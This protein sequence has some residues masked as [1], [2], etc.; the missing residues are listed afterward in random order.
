MVEICTASDGAYGVPRMHQ[1]LRQAGNQINRKRVRR[2]MRRHGMAISARGG[3]DNVTGVITH[4]DRGSQYTS[5][6]Y[7]DFCATRGMLPSVGK[8]GIC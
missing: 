7:L 3:P 4:A 6:D 8:T 2:L 5:N 1:A